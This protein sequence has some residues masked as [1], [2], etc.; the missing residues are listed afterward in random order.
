[1]S[2]YIIPAIIACICL[3]VIGIV[4]FQNRGD[5]EGIVIVLSKAIKVC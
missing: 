1:M 4:F 5:W 2:K 3:M